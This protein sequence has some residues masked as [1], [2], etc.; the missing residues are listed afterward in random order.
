MHEKLE[1]GYITNFHRI[2]SFIVG[3]EC[4]AFP[5]LALIADVPAATP[6]LVHLFSS[7]TFEYGQLDFE[8]DFEDERM[9]GMLEERKVCIISFNNDKIDDDVVKVCVDFIFIPDPRTSLFSA[10]ADVCFKKGSDHV[11]LKVLSLNL[12]NGL[13]D[14]TRE[15]DFNH[16]NFVAL[17]VAL[18]IPEQV[19]AA[20]LMAMFL[21]RVFEDDRAQNI[22]GAVVEYDDYYDGHIQLFH[23]VFKAMICRVEQRE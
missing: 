23:D 17:T 9:A 5:G 20:P 15:D 8:V 12:E 1:H 11:P 19:E 21:S 3:N 14:L 22:Y 4:P 16:D 2:P 6:A 13:Y 10:Y 7:A 18:G